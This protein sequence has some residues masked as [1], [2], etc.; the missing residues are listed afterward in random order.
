MTTATITPPPQAQTKPALLSKQGWVWTALLAAGFIALFFDFIWRMFLIAIGAKSPNVRDVLHHLIYGHF[1]QDWSHALV[2][3]FISLYYI[4]QKRQQLLATPRRIFW[5]G[6]AVLFFG[7][8]AYAFWIM[9]GRNDMFQGYSVIIA[10]FGLVLFLLGPAMMKVLWFPIVYLVFAVKVSDGVWERIAWQ[11]QQIAAKCAALMLNIFGI[12][13]TVDGSTINLYRGLQKL[14]PLNVAEACSGLRML[15]AFVA[16]GVAMAFHFDRAWWQRLIMVLLCVPIAVAVNVGRVTTLGVLHL[17][18]PEF[19][20]GD[21]H[22]FVGLLMLIPALLVYMLLGWVLDKIIIRDENESD[23]KAPAPVTAPMAPAKPARIGGGVALGSLLALLVGG[24][25]A[26]LAAYYVPDAMGMDLSPSA[27]ASLL[28]VTALALIACGVMARRLTRSFSGA[29]Q[30]SMAIAAGVLFSGVAILWGTLRINDVVRQKQPIALREKLY[31]VPKTLGDWQLK[32]EDN[33]MSE[34]VLEVLGTKD[35]FTRIYEDQ[36]PS[37]KGQVGR[38]AKLHV[39]YYTGTPDTVPHVPTRCYVAGGMEPRKD[40]VRT[41][42]LSSDEGAR[43]M[44]KEDDGSWT[45]VSNVAKGRVRV[46]QLDIPVTLFTFAPPGKPDA[47]VLY[48]FSANG[49]FLA[50]PNDVRIKGFDFRDRY[51]YYCKIEVAFDDVSDPDLAMKRAESLLNVAMPEILACLPDWAEVKA[52]ERQKK[53][54]GGAKI[55]TAGH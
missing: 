16:L 4:A 13:A 34:E 9:P 47:N 38:I 33:S 6:L 44:R 52:R 15:M 7:L 2:I 24:C 37:M 55:Q 54:K 49:K 21:T 12:D 51:S 11:L 5:P 48:F 46:P 40:E 53:S 27:A 29:Q 23:T 41:I 19:A 45:V 35:Y 20:K 10:L 18:A 14:E 3:P 26:F 1:S 36:S 42:R 17:T 31:M 8:F 32:Y 39:A 25:Y 22:K 50:S 30:V 43:F 28:V